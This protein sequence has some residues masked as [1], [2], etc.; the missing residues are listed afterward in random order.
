MLPVSPMME[1]ML[2]MR[3]VALLDHVVECRFHHVEGAGE[4]DPEDGVPFVDSHPAD[5]LVHRDAGIVDEDVDFAVALAHLV[6]D[7]R[8][9]SGWPTLP[10]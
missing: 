3:A 2:T 10:W 1:L 6:E 8:Q 4:I 9:S 7:R 5:R